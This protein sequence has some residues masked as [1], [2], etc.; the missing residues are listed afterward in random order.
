MAE[1]KTTKKV[2]T[3][4]AKPAAS[5]VEFDGTKWEIIGEDYT[6]C[7]LMK[8]ERGVILANPA[9]IKNG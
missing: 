6:G 5:Q 8:S 2:T 4:K 1:K 7:I 3:K 9:D